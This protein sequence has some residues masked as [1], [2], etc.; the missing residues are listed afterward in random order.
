METW[1]CGEVG[2]KISLLKGLSGRKVK[3][4]GGGRNGQKI[5]EE[6]EKKGKKIRETRNLTA[7]SS[8]LSYDRARGS[9]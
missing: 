6:G 3:N 9:R 7:R 1:H 4:R 8:P 2:N 5:R